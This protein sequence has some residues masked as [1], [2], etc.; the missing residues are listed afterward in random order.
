M[1]TMKRWLAGLF[2]IPV[3]FAAAGCGGAGS[4][5]DGKETVP[6]TT[7]VTETVPQPQFTVPNPMER[8]VYAFDQTPDTAQIRQMAVKAMRDMLSVQ[9]CVDREYRYQKSGS[10]SGKDFRHDPNIVYAG[11]PYTN[12]YATLV[13][14]FEYYDPETGLLSLPGDPQ[15]MN[16]LV[17]NSCAA[18]VTAA[19]L[20]VCSSIS[21][22][23]I[24]KGMVPM[25]G[26]LPVGPYETKYNIISYGDYPTETIVEDN[27]EQVMF[28]SYA[29][30]LPADSVVST[31]DDHAMMA[32]EAPHIQYNADGTIDPDLSFVAIQDQRAGS[33]NGFYTVEEDG[34][35]CNYSG[36]TYSTYT[37]RKLY[38][39]GYIPVTAKE[40]VDASAYVQPQVSFSMESYTAEDVHT[41]NFSSNYPILVVRAVLE[42]DLG[43]REVVERSIA[44]YSDFKNKMVHTFYLGALKARP[45]AEEVEQKREAGKYC[46]LVY[47]ATLSNGETFTVAEVPLNE[48]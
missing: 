9:W 34:V 1:I 40:F 38:D 20:T 45:G 29:E 28:A 48:G 7:D 23:E 4:Q 19:W 21:G 46:R 24:T 3:A 10:V 39:L 37:F 27:G 41:G 2:A 30:I 42:D 35:I 11:M 25:N 44:T 43:N 18:C 12:G 8:Q 36:R 17:G 32:V 6:V 15:N 14:W 31:K 5:S 26:F 13:H 22:I 33:G 16:T 47:E